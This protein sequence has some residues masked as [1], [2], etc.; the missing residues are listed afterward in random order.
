[1][2]CKVCN[3]EC[4]P[5]AKFCAYCGSKLEQEQSAAFSGE[6][7]TPGTENLGANPNVAENVTPDATFT[8]TYPESVTSCATNESLPEEKSNSAT[9][10]SA[11]IS[12]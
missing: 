5:N 3:Y 12:L 4:L 1:M 11:R 9:N 10:A 2:K 8:P 6:S 7:A